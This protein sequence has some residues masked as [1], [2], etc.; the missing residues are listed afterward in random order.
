M[1]EV[2]TYGHYYRSPACGWPDGGHARG[3]I[4]K[5]DVGHLEWAGWQVTP[6]PE[7]ECSTCGD[8]GSFEVDGH[9]Y[10]CRSC[11]EH[12]FY[13]AYEVA[14]TNIRTYHSFSRT[15][16]NDKGFVCCGLC[17]TL[18]PC[19]TF[20]NANDALGCNHTQGPRCEHCGELR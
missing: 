4:T 1:T 2:D 13:E 6:A 11:G 7:P 20:V 5:I 19:E 15:R 12:D 9:A 17:Q 8:T 18:W 10:P 16:H 14:L 3:C